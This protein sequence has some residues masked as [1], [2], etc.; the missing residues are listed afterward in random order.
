MPNREQDQD[1]SGR[2]DEPVTRPSDPMT[3]P[4]AHADAV[5]R[6]G[7][8]VEDQERVSQENQ[9]ARGTDGELQSA[10]DLAAANERVAARR[11]WLDYVE[12]VPAD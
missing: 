6:L 1:A 9:A 11:A 12:E 3:R 5:D 8:A 10:T 4:E 7:A 2:S